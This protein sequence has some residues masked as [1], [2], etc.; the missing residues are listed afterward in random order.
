MGTDLATFHA[1]I[2]RESHSIIQEWGRL[3]DESQSALVMNCGSS[4]KNFFKLIR[5]YISDAKTEQ[6]NEELRS[7]CGLLHRRD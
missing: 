2:V 7:S 5:R 3:P 4:A 1:P 6:S